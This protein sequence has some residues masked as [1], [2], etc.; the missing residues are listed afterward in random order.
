[1]SVLKE[2]VCSPEGE[3]ERVLDR[4]AG[5]EAVV[6]R[7]RIEQALKQTGRVDKRRCQLTHAVMLWITLAMGLLTD[8][9]IRQVFKASRRWHGRERTPHR[10]SLCLARQRL[11]IAPV[12]TLFQAVVRPLAAP[13]VPGGFYC[14]YRLVAVDG[15]VL[16]LPDTPANERAFGR[17]SGGSRGAG[18]FPQC[19]KTSLVELGTHVELDF[20]VKPVGCGETTAMQ[21]LW[22]SVPP[23][24]LLLWDR[25]FFSY[26]GWKT[27]MGREVQ[28][29]IRVKKSLVLK[30]IKNLEDGSFLA[31]IYPNWYAREKD[32]HGIVVRV[33]RYK[34][35]DPQR[36]GHAEEHTLLTS[37]LD[38]E[39]SPASE[40]IC[41]YHERWE[42]ELTFDEQKT[43]QDPRRVG[44]SAHLRSETPAGVVQELY[45]LSLAHFVIR[46]MMFDAAQNANLDPDRLSFTGCF[47]IL[48]TRLPECSGS[49]VQSIQDWYTFL[50]WE[51]S[52]ELLP[53]RRN[54]INPRVI[55]Q[56]MSNWAKKRPQHFHP[57]PLTKTFEESIVMVS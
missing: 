47:Q 38:V 8:R 10:S 56:K 54:R 50:L 57:P 55:K 18:A 6:T 9:P 15:T 53:P 17:P 30:P 13:D 40:L 4:L 35:D 34:L 48:I 23:N 25:G 28:L 16:N 45:A 51:M 5:L 36:T 12:R 22:R 11:G 26:S 2:E 39:Q 32:R 20:L 7:E 24:S 29:L 52:Q 41:L 49:S 3:P 44:K 33:I 43:H 46:K 37:L 31:K 1:M 14:G 21:A 19:R 42:E 27:A